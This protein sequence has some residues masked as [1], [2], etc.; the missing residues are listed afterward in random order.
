MTS[1]LVDAPLLLQQRLALRT[2]Y[3]GRACRLEH[4]K[5]RIIGRAPVPERARMTSELVDAPP[6]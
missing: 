2:T 5:A 3:P 4:A 1:E 6:L